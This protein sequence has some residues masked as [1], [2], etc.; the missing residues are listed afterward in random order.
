MGCVEKRNI[1]KRK[2]YCSGAEAA[3]PIFFFIIIVAK[4]YSPPPAVLSTRLF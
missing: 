1:S 2:G 4:D 3:A